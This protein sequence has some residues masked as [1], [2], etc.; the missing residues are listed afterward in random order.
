LLS[1][2]DPQSLGGEP[3]K[4]ELYNTENDPD[5]IKN[6]AHDATYRDQLDRLRK[7]LARW[8]EETDDTAVSVDK[9]LNGRMNTLFRQWG[10]I[11]R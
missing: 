2:V 4:F 7:A 11:V 10:A 9:L 3:P 5:E 8:I 6:L 1:Q